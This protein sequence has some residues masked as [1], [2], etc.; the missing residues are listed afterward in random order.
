[1]VSK[2]RSRLPSLLAKPT[3]AQA[4]EE[5]VVRI[6]RLNVAVRLR[7][8]PFDGTYVVVPWDHTSDSMT[9]IRRL[10]DDLRAEGQEIGAYSIRD[11]TP[12]YPVVRDT[13]DQPDSLVGRNLRVLAPSKS[14][15]DKVLRLLRTYALEH[16]SAKTP[17]TKSGLPHSS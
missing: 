5:D 3:G 15:R 16:R 17:R 7:K 4:T 14:S 6:R 1:M 13:P 10:L 11:D 8:S 2:S 12:H 9:L